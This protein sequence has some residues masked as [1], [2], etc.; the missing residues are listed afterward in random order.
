MK[1]MIGIA[2]F[3]FAFIILLTGVSNGVFK[4]DKTST[5]VVKSNTEFSFTL[6]SWLNEEEREQNVFIS[7]F[8]IAT[9]L[10]MTLQG[11]GTTTKADLMKSLNYN[12]R[13]LQ[14]INE[15]YQYLLDHLNN[16]DKQIVLNIS[17]SIW[18]RE[19]MKIKP[20]FLKVNKAVFKASLAELDFSKETAVNEI[21]KWIA[22]ST[23]NKITKMIDPP[24]PADVVMYLINA[25]YFKGEWT[26]KFNKADTFNSKFHSGGGATKAVMMMSKKGE[27]EYGAKDSFK[28]VRLPY[29]KGKT[30]MY[31]VLPAENIAINDFIKTLDAAKWEEIKNSVSKVKNVIL[32]LPRFKIE[33]GIKNLNDSLIALGMGKAFSSAADFSGISDEKLCISKVLHKAVIEVNEAGSEAAGAT[34]VEMTRNSAPDRHSFIANRPF[35]FFITDDVTGTVL[36]MGKL[37][38]CQK[39]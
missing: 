24:I 4:A 25:I 5:D 17:N 7:P 29:G 10:S 32:N 31:C 9:A 36:F 1:K 39:Y 12:G 6:F 23:N 14:K 21:N 28:V 16:T 26:E 20:D 13:E 37:Y 8:S 19:G 22:K 18:I 2:I 34:V 15:G 38:D 27:I 35:L 33:Y 3:I 11:A 30:S